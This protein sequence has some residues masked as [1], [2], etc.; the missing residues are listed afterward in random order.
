MKKLGVT[1]HKRG[2]VD[3][4]ELWIALFG[5]DVRGGFESSVPSRAGNIADFKENQPKYAIFDVHGD[6]MVGQTFESEDEA[7]DVLLDLLDDDYEDFREDYEVLPL[8]A[9]AAEVNSAAKPSLKEVVKSLISNERFQSNLPSLIDAAKL[10]AQVALS[11]GKDDAF[12]FNNLCIDFLTA[13]KDKKLSPALA[14]AE[15]LVAAGHGEAFGL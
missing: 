8:K 1:E 11:K 2:F 12:L 13:L 5:E 9:A 15:E 6:Q 3:G 14:A 10:A 4:K 7:E